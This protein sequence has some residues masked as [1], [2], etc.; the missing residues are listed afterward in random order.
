MAAE[1]TRSGAV[2]RS[3]VRGLR[4]PRTSPSEIASRLLRE[5]TSRRGLSLLGI[6][7]ATL[8]ALTL[9]VQW[10]RRHE[11]LAP[12]RVAQRTLVARVSFEV[13]D[14][15]AT[16][17]ARSEARLR[18]PR[19][20]VA[21]DGV[22]D[23]IAASL[24][25]LPRTVEAAG[26]L[27]QIDPQIVERFGLS[28]E[29]LA[30]I[31][32]LIREGKVDPAYDAAVDRLREL[33]EMNPVLDPV[34]W[35]QER[36]ALGEFIELRVGGQSRRISESIAI[37]AGDP[38]SLAERMRMLARRAPFS[39]EVL[40]VVVARL[41]RQAAPTF[42][43][44]ELASQEVASA[45][46][47]GVGPVRRPI[48][49]GSVIVRAGE[50]VTPGL[51]EMARAERRAYEERIGTPWSL[52]VLSASAS[53]AVVGGL[54]VYVWA[55]CPRIRR[56][57]AR[58]GWLC[59]LGVLTLAIGVH[60]TV[61]NPAFVV[62]LSAAP[63]MLLAVVLTLAYDQRSALAI[64]AA[65]A[66]LVALALRFDPAQVLIVLAGVATGVALLREV[67]ER[68]TLVRM[69]VW[70]GVVL[71]LSTATISFGVK[72]RPVEAIDAMGFLLREVA[73]DTALAGFSGLLVAGLAMFML[74][75][76]ERAFRI[77]TGLTLM[78]LRD[79][80][81]PLLREL[82]R[83]APGT[84]NHSLHVA[85][86][87]EDAADAIGARSLLTYVGA[88][89][90][91]IG[92]MNKPEYFVENQSGGVSKH[93]KLSPAM[94]L[95]VI[96]GHVKDGVEL[97]REFG[98]P[99]PLHHFIEAH[100]GTTLVEY[101]YH[102]AR[103]EADGDE[104]PTEFEYRY[105]GPKPQTKE[106]AILMLA[107]AVESATRTLKEPTPSRIDTLV[108]EIATKRLLDGQFDECALTLRELNTIVE[109]ISR[110]VAAI[111]HGRI[112]YPKDQRRRAARA[113]RA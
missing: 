109:T 62:L 80:K 94:S 103:T 46:A 13:E 11:L 42:R 52:W 24:K 4:R 5:V 36:Q 72:P 14:E 8:I 104:A 19:V 18:A 47:A 91:D 97:A 12:G 73:V 56:S 67:R 87:A 22:L 70:T 93:E 58:V 60:G 110:S 17:A 75:W 88:L 92:K 45:A 38:Q 84:Y 44:D 102:R 1:R 35:Q 78:E 43:Y 25:N 9:I 77:T 39:G 90:H 63:S 61:L 66:L 2:G 65:H 101:F 82:Q 41:T 106:C 108:R 7:I 68:R 23:E 50:K 59:V 69:G 95:L 85:S 98:L 51:I 27:E 15:A 86:I 105:P 81:Q 40:E 112:A 76:L 28:E 71:A 113:Q 53:L 31:K 16:T 34:T 26:R 111:Y 54:G 21:Q 6:G 49:A 89:Y 20:Y 55:F 57:A 37:N 100:H 99:K 29:R 107:D 74:P 96:V 30:A 64:G 10:G 32:A 79:P 3:R 83:R 48:E 33:L